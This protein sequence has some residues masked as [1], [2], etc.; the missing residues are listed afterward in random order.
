MTKTYIRML[1]KIGFTSK[2]IFGS[3]IVDNAETKLRPGVLIPVHIIHKGEENE[4][5][6]Y[7]H[8]GINY[9]C[10]RRSSAQHYYEYPSPLELLA[11]EA[12]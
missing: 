5:F 12:E 2:E 10:Y 6:V 9:R 8:Y 1:K 4:Y 3:V 7:H 11:L